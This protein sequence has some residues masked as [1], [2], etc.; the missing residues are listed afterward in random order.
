MGSTLNL[1]GGSSIPKSVVETI[2][3]AGHGFVVGDVVRY[4]TSSSTWVKAKADSAANAEVAGVVSTS[5]ANSFDVTYSGYISIS[6]LASNTSPVLFLDS[7]IAGGLTASPPSAVGTVVKPVITKSNSG[8]GYIVT[9]YLGTQIGGSSTVSI[10]QIQPV[11]TVIP[12]SGSIIPDTWLECNGASYSI[13]EYS[14]LYTRLQN[15]TGDLAPLYGHVAV[16]TMSESDTAKLSV[17]VLVT[18]SSTL[19]G[20]V[21]SKTATTVTVQTSPQYSI[22]NKSFSHP[23]R[24]FTT[25]TLDYAASQGDTVTVT[26]V[27]ITHFNVPDMRGRFAM[28]TNSSSI[29]D[30]E[31]DGFNNSIIS[32]YSLAA[33]GGQESTATNVSV[34]DSGSRRVTAASTGNPDY[35]PNLPPYLV[36]KYIIKAKPY[37]RAAIIDGLEIPYSQLL[38]RDLRTRNVGGT[39]SDLVLYTNTTGDSGTG[40]ERARI[41]SGTGNF[42]IGHDTDTARLVVRGTASSDTIPE[43]RVTS[44][45]G[46]GTVDLNASVSSGAWNPINSSGTSSLVFFRDGVAVNSSGTTFTIA[47]WDTAKTSGIIISAN[48][49]RC[50]VGINTNNPRLNLDVNGTANATRM[51]ISL[52]SAPQ[53]YLHIKTDTSEATSGGLTAS[54]AKSGMV[55]EWT[56]NSTGTSPLYGPGMWWKSSS[57]TNNLAGIFVG[58][59]GLGTCINFATS[60]S[61]G[62]GINKIGMTITD[63]KVGIGTTGPA[64]ALDIVGEARSSTSTTSGSNSKTLVTKDYVDSNFQR[65]FTADRTKV[66]GAA[67]YLTA[68]TAT[69]VGQLMSIYVGSYTTIYMPG[70]SSQ[71]WL[72]WVANGNNRGLD[73]SQGPGHYGT[74]AGIAVGGSALTQLANGTPIPY[75]NWDWHG[76]CIRIS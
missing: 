65:G 69:Q 15:S 17:G 16:L 35:I 11:G 13:S 70:N 33:F 67:N 62:S 21:L 57:S 9:N 39:D 8:S 74:L 38:V 71:T 30:S 10:D 6:S 55:M 14:E 76:F 68:P 66:A 1:K 73:R 12:Y 50:N 75:D 22:S 72:Y 4:D 60:T 44:L 64:V 24:V 42:C 32:S 54:V 34:T 63:G 56:A 61:Y 43:I 52:S 19:N 53:S 37:T 26:G 2:N 48:S 49:A 47:P 5:A 28:G 3:Q 46:D 45:N 18:Q 51:G 20:I 7:V 41:K 29:A 58:G 40:T 23:N 25:G 59:R 36:T 31:T 27:S